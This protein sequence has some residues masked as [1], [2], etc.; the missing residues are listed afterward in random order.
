MRTYHVSAAEYE[1]TLDWLGHL[2]TTDKSQR[3]YVQL[4]GSQLTQWVGA[5][6]RLM[7]FLAG[8]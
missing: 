7:Q 3:S 4:A 2:W 6:E 1:F 5:A 8:L